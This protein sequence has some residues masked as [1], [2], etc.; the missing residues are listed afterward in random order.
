MTVY[1]IPGQGGDARLFTHLEITGGHDVRHITYELPAPGLSMQEYAAILA[2]QIDTSE[3]FVIIGVSLGGM[4][5]TEMSQL[6]NAEKTIII[7]SAKSWN[8][9]PPRYR[10]QKRVPIYKMVSPRLSIFGAKLLQPIVE[11]DR[12]SQ[13]E[14][15]KAMLQDKDPRFIARTI[16]MIMQWDRTEAPDNIYHIHG[17]NDHT[18][19]ISHVAYDH[20]VEGGSHMMVLTDAARVSAAVNGVLANL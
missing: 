18:L 16:P 15:F 9:L 8:E 17:S 7:S 12:Q 5:A 6:V 14:I 3:P 13:K 4:I 19:P 11:P 2:G 1:L 10:F 20:L